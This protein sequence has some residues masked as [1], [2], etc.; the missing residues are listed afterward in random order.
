VI[1]KRNNN[2]DPINT[3][4][5]IPFTLQNKKTNP[6]MTKPKIPKSTRVI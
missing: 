6:H 3:V 1:K 2:E 4:P 5:K